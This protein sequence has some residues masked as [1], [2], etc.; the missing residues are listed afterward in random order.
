MLNFD[1]LYNSDDSNE[2]FNQVEADN[3]FSL[4]EYELDKG[5]IRLLKAQ[6]PI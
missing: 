5:I 3:D 1:F 4:D 6:T 2:D